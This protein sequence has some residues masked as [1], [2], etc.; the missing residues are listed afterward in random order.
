MDL[1]TNAGKALAMQVMQDAVTIRRPG[2]PTFNETT[3]EYTE[4]SPTV[5]SGRARIAAPT[6]TQAEAGGAELQRHDALAW[7]P[8]TAAQ[9]ERGDVLTVDT[10]HLDTTL[11]GRTYVV[12]GVDAHSHV[13]RRVLYLEG[14]P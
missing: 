14:Q 1:V 11:D 5:Y 7:I 2:G 10:T 6:V 3:G 9:I 12:V 8:L 4:N 13:A